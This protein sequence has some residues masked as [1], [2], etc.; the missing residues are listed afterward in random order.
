MW[1][2]RVEA[3][4]ALCGGIVDGAGERGLGVQMHRQTHEN[5]V[6]RVSALVLIAEDEPE[7]AEIAIAY[8]EREGIA[9][10]M[11]SMA[12]WRSNCIWR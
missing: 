12:R 2:H 1:S 8:L 4:L 6:D 7:I 3:W 11:R 5:E 10:S 9:P